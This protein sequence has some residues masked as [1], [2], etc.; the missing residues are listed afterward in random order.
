MRRKIPLIILGGSDPHPTTLP[1]GSEGRH[2]L[3]GCKGVDIK[4]AGRCL[5]DVLIDRLEASGGFDPIWIAGPA[6]VYEQ[7]ET[8]ARVIDT[9]GGFGENIQAA[10]DVMVAEYSG[11]EVAIATCDILP[12]LDELQDLLEDFWM[13]APTDLW[14]PVIRADEKQDLGASDWKPRYQLRPRT[15]ADAIS[16]L[17]GHILIFDPRSLRLDF[18]YR[19]FDLAYSTRNRPLH[20]RRSFILRRVLAGLLR[21]DFLHLLAFRLPTLTW[22]VAVHGV[23]AANRLRKGLATIEEMED[24][25]RHMFITRKH[26]QAHPHRRVRIRI[27]SSMSIARDIDT[28]E[29]AAAIGASFGGGVSA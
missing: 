20:Y 5:I 27:T 18:L 26:R 1:P 15:G 10:L 9:N 8:S 22:D 23:R 2:P 17:P 24:A 11:Q 19:L 3:S 7:A 13:C 16:I 25:V 28:V 21:Q 6:R 12:E 14:F 29:E 4:L